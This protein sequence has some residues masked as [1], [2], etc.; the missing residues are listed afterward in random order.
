VNIAFALIPEKGHINPYIGPAQAL[1]DM[2][3]RVVIAAPGD[4]GPQMER[5]GLTFC[6]ELIPDTMPGRA[7]SGEELVGLIQDAARLEQWIEQLLLTD[8]TDQ[9]ARARRWYEQEHIDVVVAD[10]LYYAGVIAAGQSHLPWAAVS[11]SLNPVVPPELDS[12]L[13]R[14]LGKL[15]KRRDRI[16]RSF[17]C[18]PA[19][20]SCDALSPYL[21]IAFATEALVGSPPSGVT[22]V[23]PS[24]PRRARGDE[25]PMSPLPADKPVVYASFGSQLYHWPQLFANL[26]DAG[27]RIGA[28]MVLSIGD[29]VDTDP[30]NVSLP[31]CD[32]YR[33]AP[34]IPLLRRCAAFVTHGGANSVME[35]AAYGVPMLI[36]PMCNDQFHQAYFI[37]RAGI[38]CVADLTRST[39]DEIAAQ[40]EYLICEPSVRQAARRVAETYQ[41]DGALETA[42]LVAGIG[43]A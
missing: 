5:A 13:L 21:T 22:L 38:G 12:A 35:A 23:G 20:C 18:Q 27:R 31:D 16:F 30:W 32:V 36:S 34:Q 29:L 41:V 17:G 9:V 42:R 24:F 39:V 7:T 43:R 15:R 6:R 4:I 10:P 8:M 37:E 1:M 28:H 14:T 26:A 2:G 19:F 33:Y 3:H 11:N 25:V 40:L